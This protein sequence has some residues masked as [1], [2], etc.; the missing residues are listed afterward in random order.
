[1]RFSLL[2]PQHVFRPQ[3]AACGQ[4]GPGSRGEQAAAGMEEPQSVR[5][6]ELYIDEAWDRFI[7]LSVRRT[8]YGAL[9]GGVAAL[10]FT[11]KP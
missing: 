3:P 4:Q 10:L 6:K 8:V 9:A 5:P 11:R 1:M 2:P 7:D